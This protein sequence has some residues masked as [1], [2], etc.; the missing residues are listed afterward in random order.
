MGLNLTDIFGT[1]EELL[2][3]LATVSGHP[4]LGLLAQKLIA[5]GEEELARRQSTQGRTRAEVLADAE[6]T[7]AEAKIANQELKDLGH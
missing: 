2:P 3:I 7:Y 4:E 1:I 6:A 5:I